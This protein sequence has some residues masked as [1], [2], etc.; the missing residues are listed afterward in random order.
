VG[1]LATVRDGTAYFSGSLRNVCNLADLK[2][3]RLLGTIDAWAAAA[4]LDGVESAYP[5][6]TRVPDAPRLAIDLVADGYD[7]VVW[8]TGFRADYSWLELPVLDR[9][10]RIRHDGGIVESPGMYLLGIP[11]LRRR[12]SSLIDGAASDARDLADHLARYLDHRPVGSG[13]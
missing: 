4:G 7:S 3:N 2:L 1:R 13:A 12:R 10:G 11:F 6:P 5:P 9:K 8:A